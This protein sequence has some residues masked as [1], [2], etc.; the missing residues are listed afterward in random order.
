MSIPALLSNEELKHLIAI[1]TKRKQMAAEQSWNRE[2]FMQGDQSILEWREV[3]GT[4]LISIRD[5]ASS[6]EPLILEFG[7]L[8]EMVRKIM[9]A[10]GAS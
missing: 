10:R 3:E 1:Y 9:K 4:S 5:V 8:C 7:Q 2:A 6:S